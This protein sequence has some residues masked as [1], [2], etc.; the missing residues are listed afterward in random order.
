M[1]I[2]D[3]NYL[4]YRAYFSHGALTHDGKQVG[5]VYGF[6]YEIMRVMRKYK[7][8]RPV[9]FTWDGAKN[10]LFRKKLYPAYKEKREESQ[11]TKE[12]YSQFKDLEKVILPQI[13]FNNIYTKKGWEADD[14]IASL[15]QLNPYTPKVIVSSDKDLYQLLDANTSM[16]NPMTKKEYT[17]KLFRNEW[18]IN[19]LSWRIVK[20][21]AGCSTD[22]VQG[23]NGVGDI[24]AA[25][26]LKQ[27]LNKDSK[28]YKKIKS[29]NAIRIYE[30]NLYLVGLPFD[31]EKKVFPIKK[32]HCKYDRFY[33]VCIAYN[34]RSILSEIK[35]W[36]KALNLK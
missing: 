31:D 15:C 23:A 26:Y 34:F 19:P 13:G 20:A 2:I 25:K 30:R 12:D 35:N 9:V 11:L 4:C 6:L 28:A 36:R 33:S 8:L 10:D 7:H 21:I 29:K 27:E 17:E 32:D 1:I 5:V 22:N 24:T 18:N 3:S 16:Y 14:I